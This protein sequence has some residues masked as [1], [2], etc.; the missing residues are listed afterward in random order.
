VVG[1]G[2][3]LQGWKSGFFCWRSVLRR[4]YL[5]CSY[6]FSL[7]FPSDSDPYTVLTCTNG[8]GCSYRML[9]EVTEQM[10][11]VEVRGKLGA[12]RAMWSRKI[13]ASKSHLNS[14]SFIL[15]HSTERQIS[16]YREINPK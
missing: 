7:I 15:T 4:S 11:F 1:I 2:T 16:K 13:R 5:I 10:T 8:S 14:Q 9:T 6:K 12:K 3:C